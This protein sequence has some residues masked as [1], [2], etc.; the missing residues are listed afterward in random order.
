MKLDHCSHFYPFLNP[1]L[2][3]SFVATDGSK[4]RFQCRNIVFGNETKPL[5]PFYLFFHPFLFLP[6]MA[7]D[8]DFSTAA[9]PLATKPDY[10]LA[11]VDSKISFGFGKSR[12]SSVT[13]PLITVNLCHAWPRNFE[14]WRESSNLRGSFEHWLRDLEFRWERL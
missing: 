7:T 5:F 13:V 10:F 14:I 4:L 11:F 9:L 8:D 12:W 2:F 3:L 6:R 1:F